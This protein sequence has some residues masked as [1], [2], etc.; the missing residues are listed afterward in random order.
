[1]PTHFAVLPR[2]EVA[3]VERVVAEND[4]FLVVEKF[5]EGGKAAIRLDP[6][7]RRAH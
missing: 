4:R 1:M 6:C 7:A 3:D 2:H 5:G